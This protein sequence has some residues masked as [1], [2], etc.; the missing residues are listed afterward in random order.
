MYTDVLYSCLSRGMDRDMAL[1]AKLVELRSA[2]NRRSLPD[3]ADVICS[4][5]PAFDRILPDGGWKRGNLVEWLGEPGSGAA[6][7]AFRSVQSLLQANATWSVIDVEGTFS[8]IPVQVAVTSARCL[9]IRPPSVA[10]SWW[11]V[12]QVL[13][14]PG[15]AVTWFRSDNVPDRVLR[16]W[17]LAAESGGGVGMLFRPLA[18]ARQHSWSDLRLKVTPVVRTSR[19][20]RTVRVEV[21]YC[22][23]RLGGQA[24]MLELHHAPN[25]LRLVS[26]LDDSKTVAGRAPFALRCAGRVG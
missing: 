14:S 8:A 5:I 2:L 19:F 24:V 17:Q 12:E 18:A 4:E 20:S 21:I 26:E 3:C 9:I 15:I 7:L 11:A 25:S 16:R 1:S 10:E 23:G 22:R 13:R 6:E